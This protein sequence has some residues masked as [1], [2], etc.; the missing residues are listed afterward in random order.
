MYLFI[1]LH[2]SAYSYV[3]FFWRGKLGKIFVPFL[4]D[5]LKICH[6]W[7]QST[8][9]FHSA[10]TTPPALLISCFAVDGCWTSTLYFIRD[11]FLFHFQDKPNDHHSDECCSY[12]SSNRESWGR[13]SSLG[14]SDEE[15]SADCTTADNSHQVPLSFHHRVIKLTSIYI[16]HITG[17]DSCLI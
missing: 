15:S 13:C 3:L 10:L 16:M 1:S 5:T 4:L 14:G 17:P 11:F 6:D 8:V 12:T 2:P 9:K 7:I